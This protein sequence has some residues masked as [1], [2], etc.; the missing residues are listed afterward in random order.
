VIAEYEASK[1]EMPGTAARV[2]DYSAIWVHPDGSA[3]MLEHEIIGLQSREAIQEH[4]EQ[5]PPRG[6]VLKIRTIK[7]DGRVLE[8]EIVE[9]K[10]TVTMPHLEVGDYI[11][12]ESVHFI[13]GDGQGGQRF[14]GPRWLFRE[15]KIPYWRSEFIVISPKN[16]PLDIETGGKVPAPKVT[17]SGALVIHDWRVD[18]SPALPEEP[19]SAPVQEF[20]P[21]VRVSWGI[22]LKDAVARLIDAAA[23]E[24]PRDPRLVRIAESIVKEKLPAQGEKSGPAPSDEASGPSSPDGKRL[25]IDERARRIY[26]W[27]LAN[28]EAGRESDARRIVIGKSGNRAEAFLYLCRL[29][30]IEAWLGLVRDRLAP[31]PNGPMS[32]VEA[33]GSVAVRVTT[34]SGPRWMVVREKFA[35]YG[36]MPSSLRGQPALVLRPNPAAGR[37]EATPGVTAMADAPRETTPSEGSKD[38]M[39]QVG[40]VDLAADGS[41]TID[42]EQRFEGKLAILIRSA[43][44]TLPDARLKE[45]VESRLL[46]Q[47]FPGARVLSVEV[48]NLADLDAP[49]ILSMKLEMST[50]ARPRPGE[51]VISPPFPRQ[52]GA[53]AALPTRETPLYLSEQISMGVAMKLAIKLPPGARAPE[54]LSPMS[55][56]DDGRTVR[57]N[58]R[59]ERGVLILDRLVNIPAGR[60]QSSAYPKFQEFARKGDAALRRDLVLTLAGE[61]R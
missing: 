58:D 25:S 26:R 38:Q 56:D 47:W 9:G 17:E 54:A 15:E 34:E 10:Q 29:S 33:F 46:P 59:V 55:A 39:T 22:N 19:A 37:S 12:T 23:D 50:F 18:L 49:M 48:K 2:L 41:A 45:T 24:T 61:G 1:E 8:P 20:L 28:V 4:A 36:Y 44:E 60:V 53:L 32:E 30:G 35:P 31:P 14:E 7:R 21:N 16:R 57:I 13:R 6:L 43:L 11:E 5:R 3:R 52:L 51:I 40:T 42:V 27:V